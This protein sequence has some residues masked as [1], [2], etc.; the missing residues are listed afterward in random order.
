[1]KISFDIDDTLIAYGDGFAT[2]EQRWYTKLLGAEKL[3]LGTIDLFNELWS[4]NHSIWIYTTSHRSKGKL[5]TNFWLHGLLIDG[6]INED[7]NR[8]VLRAANC[9]ASKNPKLF[10]IDIHVDDSRGVEIEG[11]RFGFNTII[12]EPVDTDWAAKVLDAI[13]QIGEIRK[14]P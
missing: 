1:M 12:V 11:Q 3:R 6:V 10:A 4:Q 2:E 5:M 9:S 14:G 13:I 8:K 7:K